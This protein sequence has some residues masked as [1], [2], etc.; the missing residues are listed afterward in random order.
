MT[1]QQLKA[2]REYIDARIDE[3]FDEAFGRS[4]TGPYLVRLACQT[5]LEQA[6]GLGTN[7][8]E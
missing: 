1:K 6:F 5:D 8:K 4:D 3:K 7:D 2:L